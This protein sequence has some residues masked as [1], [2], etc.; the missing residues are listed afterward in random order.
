M[1]P[2]SQRTA[3][4]FVRKARRTNVTTNSPSK[5]IFRDHVKCPMRKASPGDHILA[6]KHKKIDAEKMHTW[7]KSRMCS[8]SKQFG[9][10]SGSRKVSMP[11]GITERKNRL[12][13]RLSGEWS[14]ETS[15]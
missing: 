5:A 1:R 10:L 15:T 13:A 9:S 8:L 11:N 7:T 2:N 12:S 3:F 14:P 4:V 6:E